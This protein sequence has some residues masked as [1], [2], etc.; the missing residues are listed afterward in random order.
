MKEILR[1]Y[2]TDEIGETGLFLFNPPTGTGKTYRVLEFIFNNY[3]TICK[4]GRKIFFITNLKKNLPYEELRDNFF[5]HNKKLN[6]FDKH[7]LFI[8]SNQEFILKNLLNVENEIEDYFK[9]ADYYQLIKNCRRIKKHESNLGMLDV[10]DEFKRQIRE[11][12]EPNF[13]KRITEYLQKHFPNKKERLKAI[14]QNKKLNWIGKLYPTVYTDKKKIYF[15]SIDKFFAKNSTLIEP[16]Y[17]FHDNA[18]SKK[19]L[20]F[21]DEFDSTKDSILSNIIDKGISQKVDFIQMFNGIHL[22]LLNNVFPQQI[23]SESQE[24][25]RKKELFKRILSPQ[26]QLDSF[27]SK[28]DKICKDFKLKTSYKTDN[29]G[30]EQDSRSLLFHDFRYH[31]VLQGDKKYICIDHKPELGLNQIK[32]QDFKPA[33]K[34]GSVI[35]LLN[36]IKGYINYFQKGIKHLATNYHDLKKETSIDIEYS[37]ESALQ[38]I[39]EEFSLEPKHK[40]FLID[41]ILSERSL[42]SYDENKLKY[43]LSVYQNGFRYY[44]FVDSEEHDTVTKTFIYSFQNSPEKFI[45]KLAE[46]GKVIGI[47]ATSTLESVTGNFDINYLTSQL[48]EKFYQM[49][50]EEVTHLRKEFD[51]Q[52]PKYTDKVKIKSEWLEQNNESNIQDW[53]NLFGDED[54]AN[55]IFNKLHPNPFYRN[56]YFKVAYVFKQF[57]LK[58]D[59]Q[60]F[61]CMLNAFP[62]A[63]SPAFDENHLIQ[64]FEYLAEVTKTKHLFEID[65]V[66]NISR[67]YIIIKSKDFDTQKE[68]LLERLENGEKLF[69]ISTYQTLGA[70]QNLQYKA[71]KPENMVKFLKKGASDWNTNN[72]TDINAIYLDEPTHLLINANNKELKEN[73]FAKYLFQL[74]FLQE[75]GDISMYH[76]NQEVKFAFKN[77]ISSLH[78]KGIIQR[79]FKLES[80]Y[81]KYNYSQHVSKIIIQAIGRLC[82]TNFKSKN[83]YIYADSKVYPHLQTVNTDRQICLWEFLN[84]KNTKLSS[85]IELDKVD[86][87]EVYQNSANTISRKTNTL[88]KR[89]LETEWSVKSMDEWK[90][91]REMTLYFPVMTDDE[92]IKHSRFRQLYVQLPQTH[93]SYSYDQKGDYDEID[94]NFSVEQPFSVSE[95]S[96]RLGKFMQIPGV[97]DFFIEKKWATEFKIGRYMLTPSLFNN[98]YKGALG[99]VVG[100][101]VFEKHLDIE[102]KEID[103]EGCFEF[104][105]YK[106]NDDV[107]VDFKH[108]KESSFFSAEE[109][110][111]NIYNKL[112][113]LE[114]EK[115][116]I[117]NILS[118]TDYKVIPSNDKRIIEIPFLYNL[119]SNEFNK[120]AFLTIVSELEYADN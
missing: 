29:S 80:L 12:Y 35:A 102:L 18:I 82:R 106:I 63:Y 3:K 6:D 31:S 94:I 47:S 74:E 97:K 77:L 37:Y 30:I 90:M 36:S 111:E 92:A 9:T 107:Y 40:S 66:F 26:E 7:V 44:D 65:G 101:Y 88:I 51:Q 95:E 17:Y 96:S 11:T 87:L 16:S 75:H 93:N 43:D 62:K 104:F 91:L 64:I 38:T 1:K 57:L 119:N 34:Y 10:V 2:C 67:S 53:I 69:I 115:V 45:L 50:N 5:A 72:K 33:N 19:G 73:D 99:E 13:R 114:A 14:Q 39:L 32:F 24:W 20:L 55:E 76:L 61:L 103:S 59:I 112:N 113:T 100:K 109:E 70:G 41:N 27:K 120:E 79:S 98:I 8:D 105:D 83:I 23:I 60:S 49:T 58:D 118:E 28:A 68:G 48:G 42:Q 89:F 22:S 71:P 15:L 78:T 4:D 81:K 117:I 85:N 54:L 116:F 86:S 108:W 25:K 52:F 110:K 46:K 21:I 84:L 56:R